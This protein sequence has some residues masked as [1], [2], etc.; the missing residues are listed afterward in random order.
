MV[1]FLCKGKRKLNRKAQ[2]EQFLPFFLS[3]FSLS[4]T[5]R[6]GLTT[7]ICSDG[8]FGLKFRVDREAGKLVEVFT[9]RATMD[10]IKTYSI[11]FQLNATQ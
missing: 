7:L 8:L 10:N 3:V 11:F 6:S 2:N 5:P 4:S 9:C 1:F